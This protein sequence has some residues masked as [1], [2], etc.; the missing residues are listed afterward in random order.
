MDNLPSAR[1]RHVE[2][3]TRNGDGAH[4]PDAAEIDSVEE[5]SRAS[6][7]ASDPP[8]R[9]VLTR[10]GEPKRPSDP[11]PREPVTG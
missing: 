3:M 4:E 9:S 5:A 2:D 11:V 8:A 1:L 10:I 7:P 6:M